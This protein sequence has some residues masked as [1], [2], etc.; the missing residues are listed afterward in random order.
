VVLAL[1]PDEL[2]NVNMREGTATRMKRIQYTIY[3]IHDIDE[4]TEGTV[5]DLLFDIPYM[6]GWGGPFPTRD[7]LNEILRAGISDA[8]MSG[9]CEWEP[10]ELSESEYDEVVAGIQHDPRLTERPRPIQ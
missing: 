7:E 1:V 3:A 10:F 9:G 4:D 2:T 5:V 8:G 6:V